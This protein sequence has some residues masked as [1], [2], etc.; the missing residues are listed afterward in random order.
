MRKN[1]L[2]KYWL[3]L[4]TGTLLVLLSLGALPRRAHADIVP[5]VM[6]GNSFSWVVNLPVAPVAGSNV[7]LDLTCRA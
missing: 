1:Q 4:A 3:W 7:R 5:G 6:Q 2:R